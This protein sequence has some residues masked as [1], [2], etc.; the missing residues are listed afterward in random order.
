MT[1]RFK[2][3]VR[4]P[5]MRVAPWIMPMALLAG[6]VL[7]LFLPD[8]AF[9]ATGP[10]GHLM[11]A[12]KIQKVQYGTGNQGVDKVITGAMENIAQTIRLV[13]GG[14]A[15]VVILAAAVMNHFV[16]DPRAKDR[17]KELI[18]AA[19]VGL[20]LAAFAPQIVNFIAGL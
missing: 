11:A 20:L 19:V 8:A 9:A 15:L 1:K 13:L 4:D 18:G 3:W 7:S 14:T 16:H 2:K 12:K 6:L 5:R 17:A 10:H